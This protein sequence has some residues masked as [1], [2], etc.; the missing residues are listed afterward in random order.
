[1]SKFDYEKPKHLTD[2]SLDSRLRELNNAF[3]RKPTRDGLIEILD[4]SIEAQHRDMHKEISRVRVDIQRV[5][6]RISEIE[7]KLRRLGDE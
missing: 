4:L 3:N 1:M 2:D 5:H 6:E 7:I